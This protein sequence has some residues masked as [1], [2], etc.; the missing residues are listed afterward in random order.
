MNRNVTTSC[1][2]LTS[3]RSKCLLIL[4]ALTQLKKTTQMTKERSGTTPFQRTMS[5]SNPTGLQSDCWSHLEWSPKG[6]PAE[7]GM[8]GPQRA[9]AA[10]G[11]RRWQKAPVQETAA[12]EM[13]Y[14]PQRQ[15]IC[16]DKCVRAK[17]RKREALPAAKPQVSHLHLFSSLVI[18]FNSTFSLCIYFEFS[19]NYRVM[20]CLSADFCG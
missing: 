6:G 8:A 3:V 19:A 15:Y 14:I 11:Q 5:W 9:A 1:H 2:R 16:T 18:V 7:Q 20:I 12:R 13:L 4:D 17:I 10:S